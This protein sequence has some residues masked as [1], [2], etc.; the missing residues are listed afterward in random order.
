MPDCEG[1]QSWVGKTNGGISSQFKVHSESLNASVWE[2]SNFDSSILEENLSC[3]FWSGKPRQ[4][5]TVE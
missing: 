1:R 3:P 4:E 2:D 5:N